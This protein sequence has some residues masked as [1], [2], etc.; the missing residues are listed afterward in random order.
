M[1]TL[2]VI[3]LHILKINAKKDIFIPLFYWNKN[4]ED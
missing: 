2:A 4:G 3:Y 1:Y